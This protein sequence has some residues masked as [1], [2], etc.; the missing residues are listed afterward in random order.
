MSK[1][2]RVFSI[3]V[4]CPKCGNKGRTYDKRIDKDAIGYIN[5]KKCPTCGKT[6]ETIELRFDEFMTAYNA[7]KFD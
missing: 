2:H 1:Y 5:R 7:G 3:G 4:Y 6:W